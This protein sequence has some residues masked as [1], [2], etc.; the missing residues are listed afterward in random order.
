MVLIFT[1]LVWV[2]C[3]LLVF[4]FLVVVIFVCI[5]SVAGGFVGCLA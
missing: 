3:Y 5:C 2:G 4:E 1:S